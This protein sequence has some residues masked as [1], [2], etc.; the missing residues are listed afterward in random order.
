MKTEE[1]L[2]P[3]ESLDIINDMVNQA[4]F[5]FSRNSIYF[6]VWGVLLTAAA[7]FQ[8]TAQQTGLT[9]IFWIGWPL[10]GTLGG[11][12]SAIKSKQISNELTH[13][14]HLDRM[15]GLIWVFYFVTLIV[16]LV[17]LVVNRMDPSGYIMAMTGLPTILTGKLIRFKP[18]VWGGLTFW[19]LGAV[20]LF[21]VPAYGTPLFVL[22]MIT[23]YLVPGFMMRNVKYA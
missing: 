18:L 1:T 5:N 11:L 17:A 21:V 8:I 23:G 15:Y 16:V 4:R 3:N 19:I 12:F 6:I 22:S 14:S 7:L 9:E 13:E 10:A 2:T 20:A